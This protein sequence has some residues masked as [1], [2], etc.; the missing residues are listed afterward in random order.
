MDFSDGQMKVLNAMQ[1]RILQAMQVQSGALRQEIRDG[2]RN[3]R[4]LLIQE[5][6][7]SEHRVKTELR[8]DMENMQDGIID[9]IDD[10]LLPQI[11]KLSTRLTKLETKAI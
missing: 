9:F 1:E 5:I 10:R 6:K 8:K 11:D 7:A 2:D 4:D 3:T